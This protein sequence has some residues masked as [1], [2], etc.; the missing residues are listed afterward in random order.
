[1]G[2]MKAL[3]KVVL[4]CVWAL[5]FSSV[6]ADS[7]VSSSGLQF[8]VPDDLDLTYQAIPEIDEAQKYIAGWNQDQLDYIVLVEKLPPGWLDSKVY[9]SGFFRDVKAA[10]PNM[11]I[12]KSER[13]DSQGN[14]K[15]TVV[16]WRKSGSTSDKPSLV[17]FLTD[18]KSSYVGFVTVI[19]PDVDT[20]KVMAD[21]VSI[22]KLASIASH[23]IVPSLE[24]KVETDYVGAWKANETLPN[25]HQL[26]AYMNLKNDLSFATKVSVNG[27]D[28]LEATGSWYVKDQVI[29]WTYLY[30][31]P[32]LP[33]DAKQDQDSIVDFDASRLTLENQKTG[34]RHVFSRTN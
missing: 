29:Y 20:E 19:N 34:V 3:A 28:V 12:G 7:I 24:K 10:Y 21:T 17:F 32:S 25:G 8:D 22:F 27:K 14:L 4:V 1:M 11:K 9:L 5:C 16:E 33:S 23:E 2:I 6:Y 26:V 13:F 31:N 15:S 18:K 30:S